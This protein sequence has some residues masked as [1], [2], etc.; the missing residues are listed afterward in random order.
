MH[1]QQKE[2]QNEHTGAIRILVCFKVV[3]DL[4]TVL[5]RDWENPVDGRI[6]LSYTRQ[7]LAGYDE[8]ALEMALRIADQAAESGVSAELTAL[9]IGSERNET[10]CKSLYA[11]KF[12][13]VAFLHSARDLRFSPMETAKLIQFFV[14]ENGN[15]DLILMGQQASV[16][17]SGVVYWM[18]AE[19]LG[20]PALSCVT[21]IEVQEDGIQVVS[22]IEKWERTFLCQMPLVCAIRDSRYP[23]LR[24]PTIREKL[25]ASKRQTAYLEEPQ[26]EPAAVNTEVKS[27]RRPQMGRSCVRIPGETTDQRAEALYQ[28]L[29]DAGVL[30]GCV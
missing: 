7:M 21:D 4:D 2:N 17:D 29:Q 26:T 28:A 19:L 20:L 24:V 12:H 9:C 14:K 3:H 8:A 13:R 15:Y 16:G 18:T 10:I 5:E 23:Y 27:L 1:T 22:E 11:V 25:A 30:E 6:D